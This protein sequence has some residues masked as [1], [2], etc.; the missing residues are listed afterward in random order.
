M[1][2]IAVGSD[3]KTK[4]TDFVVDYLKKKGHKVK[5]FG[6]LMKPKALWSEVAWEV[7]E[8]IKKGRAGEAILMCWTG[9]GVALAASKVPGI[10][11]VTVT[12]AK[13][14]EGARKWNQANILCFSCF[15]SKTKVRKILDTWF[16]TAHSKDPEDV[17]G[18]KT[19]E[20]IEKKYSR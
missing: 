19:L 8:E 11:A 6:A 16:T 18:V 17:K 14:T 9:T 2:T 12:D 5:L 7:A 10:R 1:M 4:T 13:A 20:K 3:E 15:L